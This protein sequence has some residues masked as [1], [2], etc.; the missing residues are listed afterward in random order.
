[1]TAQVIPYG[2][3]DGSGDLQRT[4]Q[5]AYRTE[6]VYGYAVLDPKAIA[7]LKAAK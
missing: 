7:C 5:I 1:M 6:G 2:D 3:P 4:N